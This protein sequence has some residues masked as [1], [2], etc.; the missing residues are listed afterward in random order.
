MRIIKSEILENQ[1][2][3]AGSTNLKGY[4]HPFELVTGFVGKQGS[5]KTLTMSTIACVAGMA[6]PYSDVV[7]KKWMK[8]IPQGVVY[9]EVNGKIIRTSFSHVNGTL[10]KEVLVYD[11]CEWKKLEQLEDF[12]LMQKALDVSSKRITSIFPERHFDGK[13]WSHVFRS[14]E[15]S[16]FVFRL[17]SKLNLIVSS[18]TFNAI[19]E[20]LFTSNGTQRKVAEFSTGEARLLNIIPSIGLS[21][22]HGGVCFLDTI[23]DRIGTTRAE[24]LI[25][26][27][28]DTECLNSNKTQLIF[29][30]SDASLLDS[31]VLDNV[32]LY[33]VTKGDTLTFTPLNTQCQEDFSYRSDILL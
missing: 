11:E 30:S 22:Y 25:Q 33:Q 19:G 29:S 23:E 3:F 32:S 6:S 7:F 31:S 18:V 1:I 12:N 8:V 28:K 21:L 24:Q 17:L 2:S 5:G 15:L 13:L 20:A 4:N 9:S 27:F 26:I 14:P 10:S 16:D